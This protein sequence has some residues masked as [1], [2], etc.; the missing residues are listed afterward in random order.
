[1]LTPFSFAAL[2]VLVGTLV[3]LSA[4]ELATAL[5]SILFAFA[6]TSAIAF[7]QVKGEQ[8]KQVATSAIL[9]LSI[10]C[11]IGIYSSVFVTEHQLLSPN[12]I[13]P[14]R[15][16]EPLVERKYIRDYQTNKTKTIDKLY[17]TGHLTA[18]Q[19][20]DSLREAIQD[21]TAGNH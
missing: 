14:H 11:L 21:T 6:G 5:L 20:Y 19:A 18:A 7:A 2:G 4:S 17:S 9:S 12:I 10:G 15:F 1:M 16:S 8:V 13:R 3:G